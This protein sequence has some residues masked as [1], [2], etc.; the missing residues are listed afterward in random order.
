L[1]PNRPAWI[2]DGSLL[3]V[4]NQFAAFGWGLGSLF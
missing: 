2:P 1:R 3:H 4:H